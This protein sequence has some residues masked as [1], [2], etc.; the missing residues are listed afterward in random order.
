[1]DI[2]GTLTTTG[3]TTITPGTTSNVYSKTEVDGALNLKA[4]IDHPSFTGVLGTQAI[5]AWSEFTSPLVMT[6]TIRAPLTN[7]DVT[8]DDNLIITGNAS[9]GGNLSMPT[10]YMSAGRDSSVYNGNDRLETAFSLNNSKVDGFSTY[11]MNSVNSSGT[12][13]QTGKLFTGQGVMALLSTT[14]HSLKLG[15][16]PAVLDVNPEPQI[17][18]LGTGTRGVTIKTPTIIDS[19]LTVNGFIS[20]KPY[21]SLKITTSGG[22]PSTLLNGVTTIGTPGASVGI[23][24]GYTSAV[25]LARGTPGATNAFLYTIT[26]TTAH[27]LG[28]NYVV[29]CNFQGG[30]TTNSSPNGFFRANGTSN[31][32]TV[33]VRTSDGIIKDENLYVYSVP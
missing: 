16:G 10:G 13:N 26:W 24:C 12:L 2:Q 15:S 21:V 19:N 1:M 17:E 8:I 22:T 5:H 7:D 20:A 29:M 23:T 6:N 11:Y 14:N 30:S 27:P 28:S 9:V 4:P 33:W 3:P 25:T 31:S 18:I 32:I